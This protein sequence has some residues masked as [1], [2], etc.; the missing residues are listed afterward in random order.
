MQSKPNRLHGTRWK[1]LST[2]NAFPAGPWQVS[3]KPRLPKLQTPDKTAAGGDFLDSCPDCDP[4]PS[5][6]P[7]TA[8]FGRMRYCINRRRT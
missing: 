3:E 4:M 2:A 8:V 5:T 1:T 6:R 7:E